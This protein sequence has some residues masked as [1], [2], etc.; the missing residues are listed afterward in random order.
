MKSRKQ[1][2]Y[3]RQ[4]RRQA[5]KW[6]LGLTNDLD[7]GTKVW[8]DLEQKTVPKHRNTKQHFLAFLQGVPFA[9]PRR[10]SQRAIV[11]HFLGEETVYFTGS[12]GDE[13]LLLL[14]IDCHKKGS[15][16]GARQF[17]EYLKRK[18]FPNLYYETSTNGNGIH[19]YILVDKWAWSEADYN[20]ALKEV[21]KWLK[22]VLAS[23]DFDVETVELKGWCPSVVWGTDHKRQVSRFTM[24]G[25]AKMPRDWTRFS[26]WKR[27]TRLTADDLKNLP[28]LHPVEVTPV[29]ELKV[30]RQEAAASVRGKLIDKG[31]FEKYLPLAQR[32]VPEPE[33][34]SAQVQGRG[35]RR[36]RGDL[37]RPAGVLRREPES[38]RL[39]ASQTIR[40]NVGSHVP[41][42]RRESGVRQQEVR[43]GQE[44]GLGVRRHRVGGRDLQHGSRGREGEGGEMEGFESVAG[45]DGGVRGESGCR[46]RG[47]VV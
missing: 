14:D 47:S 38:G 41:R 31:K 46:E 27:T 24:G 15:P 6:L 36:G 28:E 16:E 3:D 26:E 33:L 1:E 19:G 23:T 11:R 17:A 45:V 37:P 18:Y 13:T 39:D 25:L 12:R 5:A 32:F 44:S 8:D 43:L 21:E 35:H 7:W 20:V 42:R 9:F 2:Q 10:P 4:A 22:R 34:V 29:V 40:R 30:E